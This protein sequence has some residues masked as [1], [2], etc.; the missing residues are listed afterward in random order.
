MREEKLKSLL[1]LAGSLF[2]AV[3]SLAPFVYM[4]ATSLSADP[5]FLAA[6]AHFEFTWEHY[7]SIL[8][9]KSLHFLDYQVNS[10]I[11][12]AS[13]AL[14][15]VLIASLAAFAVTRLDW[16]GKAAV[17]LF[18]VAVS[19]FPQICLISYLFKFMGAVG[20]IDTYPAL[21]LPYIAW[22][23]PL[24][25]WVLVS[26]FAG[27]PRDLDRA[28]TVD[29]C[30]R[31]QVLRRVILPV[32]RPGVF[33]ALLLAFIFAYNEF[34]LALMLT[35]DHHAR[36]I[37]VG[38]AFFEGLHGQVLWGE[39]TAAASFSTLPLVVLILVFQRHIMQGLTMGAIKG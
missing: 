15:A 28:A 2:L 13:S 4:V 1:L 18:V 25:L 34:L 23:L 22:T 5:H 37:P 21:V 24:S 30:S 9:V 19:M 16:P 20:L 14:A 17:M 7:Y 32:A 31:V 33:S 36:T 26:Y 11:V 27:I 12:S 35:T 3:F 39:I 29:G 6:R 8:T 10:L 38:I